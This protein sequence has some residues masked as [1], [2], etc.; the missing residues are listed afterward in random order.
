M[1][2]PQE[3][4]EQLHKGNVVLFCGAGISM[5]EGGL[6]SGAQLVRELAQRAKLGSVGK[7]TLPE[8]AQAYELEMGHQSLIAYITSRIDNPRYTP[9]RAHRL[10]AALPFRRV[11]TTN[12]D[13]L[14]GETLRQARKSFVKVVRDADVTF[15]DEEKILLIKLHGSIEQKDSIVVTGDDYYDVFTR[16]PETANLVRTYFATKI[17][18]F[19]GF[20]L[21]DADFKRLYHEVVRHLGKHKRRAYAVQLD[22]SPLT[23]KYWQQK[24]VQIIAADATAFLETVREE[25]GVAEPST[26]PGPKQHRLQPTLATPTQRKPVAPRASTASWRGN[27]NLERGLDALKARLQGGDPDVFLEFATLESRLCANIQ[28]ERRFGSSETVRSERARIVMELNRLALAH[29][30]VSFNVLC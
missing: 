13:N 3:L 6:P 30:E 4:Q 19:L 21:A 9:L 27:L 5:S 26:L 14:L 10:I 18:L 11:I 22:P 2:I 15:A 23:V 28:D 8:V 20:G 17:V 29:C 16:L 25:L 24:N 7:M 1:D 12:W